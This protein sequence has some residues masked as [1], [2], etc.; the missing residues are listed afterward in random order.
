MMCTLSKNTQS[1]CGGLVS[2]PDGKASAAGKLLAVES[3]ARVRFVSPMGRQGKLR[4]KPFPRSNGA[5]SSRDARAKGS[6]ASPIW[7]LRANSGIH[8]STIGVASGYF[9][10][11][12]VRPES[13]E[14]AQSQITCASPREPERGSRRTAGGSRL[15]RIPQGPASLRWQTAAGRNIPRACL[16]QLSRRY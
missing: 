9:M 6:V 3:T 2:L 5:Q 11:I 4:G 15:I 1:G 14:S 8:N 16:F 7:R 10:P 12:P 13:R